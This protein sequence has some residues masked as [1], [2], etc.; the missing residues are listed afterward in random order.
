MVTRAA[1]SPPMPAKEGWPG[2]TGNWGRWPN[3][4]GTL[5]LITPQVVLR[6]VQTVSQGR[7]FDLSRPVTGREPLRA[8]PG[9]V[10]TMLAAGAWDLEPERPESLNASDKVAYRIHGMVNTHLDALSHVGFAGFGFNG[11]PFADL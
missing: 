5:N 8:E 11:V 2:H 3:D 6:A 7:V 1:H 4:R 9:F 10:H